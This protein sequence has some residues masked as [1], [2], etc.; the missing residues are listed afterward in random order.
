M[1]RNI[2]NRFATVSGTCP[3]NQ[4]STQI[5][6]NELKYFINIKKVELESSHYH[7]TQLDLSRSA[8]YD[9][10]TSDRSKRI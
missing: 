9:C 3:L 5:L 8:Q 1:D 4:T 6:I 2:E 10:Y 7:L